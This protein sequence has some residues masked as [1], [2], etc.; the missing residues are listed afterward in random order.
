MTRS[1]KKTKPSPLRTNK[2]LSLPVSRL[3]WPHKA[4]LSIRTFSPC[5]DI[6][7]RTEDPAEQVFDDNV[8]NVNT[9][10]Q[11]IAKFEMSTN[12]Q[13]TDLWRIKDMAFQPLRVQLDIQEYIPGL[14]D[15]LQVRPQVPMTKVLAVFCYLEIETANLTHEI[16]TRFFDPLI[17]FGE[18]GSLLDDP[19]PLEEQAGEIEIQTSRILPVL[20]AFFDCLQK[21]VL[22]SKNC[23]LQMNGLFFDKYPLYKESFKKQNYYSI[24]DNLGT[25]LTNLYIVDLII[26]DNDSFEHYWKTYNAMFQ[27]VRSNPDAYTIDRKMLRRLS[28]FVERMYANIL[29]GNVYE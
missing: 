19:R 2:Y 28:K 25:I 21:V 24:F 1:M 7:L 20:N 9:F 16:E 27:K 6:C 22:L 23:L 3:V 14:F 8:T 17:Y 11:R 29:A 4:L 12:S 5:I 26:K 10:L 15:I 18:N 13:L